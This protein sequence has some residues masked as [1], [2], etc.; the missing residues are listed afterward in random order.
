M[1]DRMSPVP[2]VACKLKPARPKKF[3]GGGKRRASGCA[4]GGDRATTA[5][6]VGGQREQQGARDE[7]ELPHWS[8]LSMP[9]ILSQRRQSPSAAAE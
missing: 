6:R 2:L 8:V 3:G 9:V 4:A 7:Y 1:G 5:G